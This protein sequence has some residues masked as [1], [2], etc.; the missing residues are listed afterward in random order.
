[1][2]EERALDEALNRFWNAL[3]Q[4][5]AEPSPGTLDPEQAE[6][7]RR[8]HAMSRTPL[9]MEIR[10]RVDH[11]MHEHYA[12]PSE[13]TPRNG[14]ARLDLRQTSARPFPGIEPGLT[15]PLPSSAVARSAQQEAIGRVRWVSVQFATA[16]LLVLTLLV[17]Y[18]AFD[19]SHLG[20]E[21]ERRLEISAP[22]SSQT[23]PAPI[24]DKD[25]ILLQGT[26]DAFPDLAYWVG[27]GR[28][29]LDPGV[30]FTHGRGEVR[31]DGALLLGVE[32]GALTLTADGPITVTR[33]G[34]T[35]PLDIPLGTA[36][37][38]DVGDQGFTP[39]GVA[40]HWRNE[41]A[42]PVS[43]LET[44]VMTSGLDWETTLAGR[45]YEEIIGEY[46]SVLLHPPVQMTVR[47]VTLSRDATLA[48]DATP[49]LEMLSVEAGNLVA[50]DAAAPG[51][52]ATPFAFDDGTVMQGNFRPGR[53]FRSAD[54]APVTLLL[55]TITQADSATPPPAT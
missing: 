32:S 54:G 37:T 40:T 21:N 11:A 2:A 30:E 36:V 39:T 9:P 4:S 34:A 5:G 47:R 45:S 18:V 29:V 16:L 53:V 46:G 43:V 6:T 51:T 50:V 26:I 49:G 7:L 55:M 12:T 19:G 8:L 25:R 13:E 28:T 35:D 14:H 15:T 3:V 23:A 27:I 44:G 41:G 20:R 48:V 42:T 38:L 17:G 1:M 52:P 33:A 22:E 24:S 31:G 10:G